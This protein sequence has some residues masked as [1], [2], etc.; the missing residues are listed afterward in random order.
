LRSALVISPH[1]DDAALSV[2][3]LLLTWSRRRMPVQVVNCFTVSDYAPNLPGLA[4]AEVTRL[5]QEEDRKVA[6]RLGDLT[7]WID[8]ELLDAPLRLGCSSDIVCDRPLTEDDA[9]DV[10]DL[11]RRLLARVRPGSLVVAP[12]AVGGHIDHAVARRAGAA[13]AAVSPIAFYEDLPYTAEAGPGQVL[14]EVEAAAAE[15][16]RSLEPL[17]MPHAGAAPAK[18]E[19]AR[20]YAS[21]LSEEEIRMV[22]SEALRL[23]GERLWVDSTAAALLLNPPS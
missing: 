15:V 4:V 17:L 8:L 5:R 13:L 16:R 19:L 1:R 23:G 14:A 22:A 3:L 9:G 10:E 18:E 21:Q 2:G 20:L 7:G 12:L 11:A 6:A